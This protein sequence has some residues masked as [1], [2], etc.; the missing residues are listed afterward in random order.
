M[1]VLVLYS[2]SL[3]YY[4]DGVIHHI[5]MTLPSNTSWIETEMTLPV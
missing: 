3:G 5:G 1:I 4:R 2:I